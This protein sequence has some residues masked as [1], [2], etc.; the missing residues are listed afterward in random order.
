MQRLLNYAAMKKPASQLFA[1]YYLQ[2][3]IVFY[4][5]KKLF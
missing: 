3:F 5:I 4:S 1:A 2:G